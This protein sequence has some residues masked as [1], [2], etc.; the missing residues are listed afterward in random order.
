MATG[1][2]EKRS[3]MP[4]EDTSE[5]PHEVEKEALDYTSRVTTGNE[6]EQAE[7]VT[8]GYVTREGRYGLGLRMIDLAAQLSRLT[9]LRNAH[10]ET[11]SIYTLSQRWLSFTSSVSSIVLISVRMSS[12]D[13]SD[14][15][16][17]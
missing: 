3:S 5:S 13:S 15:I 16:A 1:A 4:P 6:A 14:G 11:R 10:S 8:H 12:R 7:A 9:Q 17:S 2:S